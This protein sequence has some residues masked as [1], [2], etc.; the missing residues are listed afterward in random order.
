MLW[1]ALRD[2]FIRHELHDIGDTKKW[3]DA[4]LL[5]WAQMGM[6]DIS[7]RLSITKQ[8]ALTP[9][10]AVRNYIL[11]MTDRV[12]AILLVEHPD[13]VFLEKMNYKPGTSRWHPR[14]ASAS[15][16]GVTQ[17]GNGWW[18]MRVGDDDVLYLTQDPILSYDITVHYAAQR[19]VPSEDTSAIDL[20]DN[21]MEILVAFVCWRA[22]L[23]IGGQD[24]SLSR[25]AE[26]PG[27]RDDNPL[28]PAWKA[29]KWRYDE[30]LAEREPRPFRRL[31]RRG[32]LA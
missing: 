11:T 31:Y 2:D 19:N 29:W 18:E 8:L 32:R 10:S 14:I 12:G 4:E 20:W 16:R 6:R 1:S 24:A 21:D 23:R 5:A 28:I 3:S 17:A 27:K 22:F 7:T 9:A 25:W 13:G 30:L 15:L 26:K